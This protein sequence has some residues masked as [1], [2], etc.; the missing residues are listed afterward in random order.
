MGNNISAFEES[1]QI[2]RRNQKW[3][4]YSTTVYVR[5]E[6]DCKRAIRACV[7]KEQQ[8]FLARK[9]SPRK[10]SLYPASPINEL[11][12]KRADK[13]RNEADLL[14]K[15]ELLASWLFVMEGTSNTFQSYE[16]PYIWGNFLRVLIFRYTWRPP[17]TGQT[18]IHLDAAA[19]FSSLRARIVLFLLEHRMR[20]A[21]SM[22]KGFMRFSFRKG[23]VKKV[24]R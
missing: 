19:M 8:F 5:A 13:L 15:R 6:K 1:R 18:I 24:V 4:E 2:Y 14:M 9:R 22:Q 11:I 16:G 17:I 21:R 20:V 23:D 10:R 12:S 3:A 7:E